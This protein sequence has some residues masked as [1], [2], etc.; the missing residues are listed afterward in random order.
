MMLPCDGGSDHRADGG[1]AKVSLCRP[2]LAPQKE[3]R[4]QQRD[5]G[6]QGCRHRSGI[7]NGIE[8]REG[9]IVPAKIIVRR[10]VPVQ[11][12]VDRVVREIILA[13]AGE[14]MQD[15]EIGDM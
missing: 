2:P 5:D 4:P 7:N 1:G 12:S 15:V 14:K 3:G 11:Y 9:I 8:G 13:M 6:Y 10:Q